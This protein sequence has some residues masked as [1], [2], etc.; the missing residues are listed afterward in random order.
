MLPHL[1]IFSL[2][3]TFT[4]LNHQDQTYLEVVEV[5]A[6]PHADLR[7]GVALVQPEVG[8]DGDD[9]DCRLTL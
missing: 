8:V 3:S 4:D 7:R 6:A 2:G 9:A 5:C 1:R